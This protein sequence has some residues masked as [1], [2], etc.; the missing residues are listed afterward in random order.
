MFGVLASCSAWVSTSIDYWE[1]PIVRWDFH[2]RWARCSQT[3]PQLAGYE[4]DVRE[5]FEGEAV[6]NIQKMVLMKDVVWRQSS[7]ESS[8]HQ[9]IT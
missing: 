6:L 7:P 2:S 4:R 8:G 5:V 3:D 9:D 1:I